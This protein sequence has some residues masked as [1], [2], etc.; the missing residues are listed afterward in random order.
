MLLLGVHPGNVPD[1]RTVSEAQKRGIPNKNILERV[2]GE[3]SYF[4]VYWLDVCM[5]VPEN[6]RYSWLGARVRGHT[7]SC[8]IILGNVYT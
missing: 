3:G 2:V 8:C 1:H 6:I 4:A 5:R 7:F